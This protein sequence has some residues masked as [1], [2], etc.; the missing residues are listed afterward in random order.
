MA[1]ERDQERR[2]AFGL[3]RGTC[4]K[5]SHAVRLPSMAKPALSPNR[6]RFRDR[7]A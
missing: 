6:I 1:A 7:R 5:I 4:S 2:E 3:P